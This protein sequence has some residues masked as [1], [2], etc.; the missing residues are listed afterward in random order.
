MQAFLAAN[1]SVPKRFYMPTASIINQSPYPL[2]QY[3]T[4][5]ASGMDIRAH[6]DKPLEIPPLGRVLIPTGIRIAL[7]EGYEAQVRPRSGLCAKRGLMAFLGT[8]DQ[9]YRGE[10]FISLINL[11][12]EA[13]SIEPGERVAQLVV[14]PYTQVAWEAADALPDTL[15]GAQ[16]FGSTGSH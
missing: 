11:S 4:P 14:A 7:P 3:A 15:R 16:G 10:I 6:L 8:I 5:G 12:P 13:Q 1:N 2:P 9:D